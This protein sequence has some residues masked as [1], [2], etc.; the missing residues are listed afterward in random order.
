VVDG[1]DGGVFDVSGVVVDGDDG[2]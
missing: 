1:A 2:G